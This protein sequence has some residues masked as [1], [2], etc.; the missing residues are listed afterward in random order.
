[1]TFFFI[2]SILQDLSVEQPE[3]WVD[4]SPIVRQNCHK[5][6]SNK[7]LPNCFGKNEPNFSYF[8]PLDKIQIELKKEVRGRIGMPYN[9]H[10]NEMG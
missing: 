4:I 6:L 2:Q 3:G 5:I 7:N 10:K 1:M 8:G 9:C